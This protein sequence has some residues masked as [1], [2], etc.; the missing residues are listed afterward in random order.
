M[1]IAE[2]ELLID[3]KYQSTP[4]PHPN[5]SLAIWHFLTAAE[6]ALRHKLTRRDIPTGSIEYFVDRAKY[7]LKYGLDRI[8]K[9]SRNF[10]AEQFP[11]RAVASCYERG[12][13][14][15]DAGLDYSVGCQICSSVHNKTNGAAR[16]RR[17]DYH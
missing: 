5:R 17:P 11:R 12:F 6:D 15:L 7:S 8:E 14:L 10:S 3:E 16:V 1:S 13:R 4:L 2:I 9:E